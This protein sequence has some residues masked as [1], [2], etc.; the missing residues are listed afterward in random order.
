MIQDYIFSCFLPDCWEGTNANAAGKGTVELLTL[1]ICSSFIY[2]LND[3]QKSFSLTSWRR[4]RS[5]QPLKKLTDCLLLEMWTSSFTFTC[6]SS[7]LVFRHLLEEKNVLSTSIEGRNSS[8]KQR[9]SSSM[10][11]IQ[12]LLFGKK[13]KIYRKKKN[14]LNIPVNTD[15]VL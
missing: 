13:K 5:H 6:I 9:F 14:V 10:A 8:L 2:V 3:C 15:F 4:R 12:N 7:P 11:K 1:C